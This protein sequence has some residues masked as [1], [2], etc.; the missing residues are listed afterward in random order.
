MGPK[1]VLAKCG[2]KDTFLQLW[3]WNHNKNDD[4]RKYQK[5]RH[6]YAIG[7]RRK[8]TKLELGEQSTLF[9]PLKMYVVDTIKTETK[10]LWRPVTS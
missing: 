3:I 4:T 5:T 8:E 10:L 6:R 7:R 9:R 1:I 2:T